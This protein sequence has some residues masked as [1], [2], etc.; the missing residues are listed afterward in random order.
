MSMVIAKNHTRPLGI[1]YRHKKKARW[2]S[3]TGLHWIVVSIVQGGRR[4][5]NNHLQNGPKD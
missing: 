4:T 5:L 1:L 3:Q 2:F